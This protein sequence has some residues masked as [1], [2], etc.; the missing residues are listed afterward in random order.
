MIVVIYIKRPPIGNG[1]IKRYGLVEVGM[2]L[3]KGSMS[4]GVGLKA[5]DAQARPRIILSFCCLLMEI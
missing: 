2:D 4:L 3:L 1:T 5:S